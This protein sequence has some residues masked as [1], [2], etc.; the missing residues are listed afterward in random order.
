A[1]V[2]Q[3]C[4]QHLGFDLKRAIGQRALLPRQ[5]RIVNDRR[6]F[7]AALSHVAV[8]R[9]PAGVADAAD[10][11]APVD[12]IIRIEHPPRWLDPIDLIRGFAPK[13]LRVAL[14]AGVDLV[15]T[16]HSAI[17]GAVL[18]PDDS[19]SDAGTSVRSGN[20][21]PSMPGRARW[22][23]SLRVRQSPRASGS[24]LVL[25]QSSRLRRLQPRRR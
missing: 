22:P 11:P 3:D 2:A 4:S 12:A 5:R 10:E 23:W 21:L 14:P 1:Q 17:H 18:P 13:P 24:F 16:A 19:A 25:C 6:L 15:I 20:A 8:D 7:A 9:I